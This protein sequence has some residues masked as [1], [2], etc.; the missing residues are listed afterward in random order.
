[1]EQHLQTPRSR[2]ADRWRITDDR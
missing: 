1:V 2:P